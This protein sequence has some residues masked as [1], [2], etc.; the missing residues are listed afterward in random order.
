ML[1]VLVFH[2]VVELLGATVLLAVLGPADDH[3]EVLEE[4]QHFPRLVLRAVVRVEDCPTERL[5]APGLD[6]FPDTG[7]HVCCEYTSLSVKM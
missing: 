4:R 1:Q 2:E 6:C 5:L 7:Q 3:V